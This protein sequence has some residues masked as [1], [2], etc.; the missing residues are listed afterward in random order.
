MKKESII[1]SM[2][3]ED[4]S[5]EEKN[6]FFRTREKQIAAFLKARGFVFKGMEKIR[7]ENSRGRAKV[8]IMFC[9]EGGNVT[10]RSILEYY[11][12]DSISNHNINA[13]KLMTEFSAITSLIA[14]F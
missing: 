6:S 2:Y 5:E 4:V 11:N 7:L 8:I 14:N 10:R 1:D 13:K 9:F 3:Y 12:S